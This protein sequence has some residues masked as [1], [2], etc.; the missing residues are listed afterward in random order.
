MKKAL[1]FMMMACV[2]SSLLAQKFS[3]GFNASPNVGWLTSADTDIEDPYTFD[4]PGARLGFSY[5]IMFEYHLTDNY[6]VSLDINHLMTGGK[7]TAQHDDPSKITLP[8]ASAPDKVYFA[9]VY[10]PI[11]LNYLFL[12]IMLRLK[13]NEIGYMRY[14]GNIGFAGAFGL[15]SNTDVTL[16]YYEYD[17]DN[18]SVSTIPDETLESIDFRNRFIGTYFKVGLGAQ[19]SM[20]GNTL[21]HFGLDYNLGLGSIISKREYEAYSNLAANATAKNSFIS[22]NIG[23]FL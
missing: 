16:S 1:L 13:T 12:P 2:S 10:D 11:R 14:F 17:T 18:S 3:L 23:I 22:L 7:F 4:A 21:L 8:D 6:H 20:G 5:G 9:T 15:G 19:Y